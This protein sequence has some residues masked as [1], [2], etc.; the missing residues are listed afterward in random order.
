MKFLAPAVITKAK[1]AVLVVGMLWVT[2][3]VW[4]QSPTQDWI[5]LEGES[6]QTRF[7]VIRSGWGRTQFLSEEKWLH[8]SVDQGNVDKVVPEEGILHPLK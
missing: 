2:S 1:R 4:A 3:V 6:A 8:I 5:W 7:K